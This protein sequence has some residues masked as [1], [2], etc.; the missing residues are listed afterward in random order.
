[1][2][3]K[4]IPLRCTVCV[5]A[6]CT[7]RSHVA[8]WHLDLDSAAPTTDS[9]GRV[10]FLLQCR[11]CLGNSL[12][13]PMPPPPPPRDEDFG[14]KLKP[15]SL[16]RRLEM[17]APRLVHDLAPE[18]TAVCVTREDG[19]GLASAAPVGTDATREFV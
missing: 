11:V 6:L 8:A 18:F 17:F 5:C 19:A 14:K 4:V 15:P 10:H 9:P 16:R 3:P 2:P 7:L 13:V 12:V 1:M